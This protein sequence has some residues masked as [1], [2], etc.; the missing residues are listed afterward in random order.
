MDFGV[1]EMEIMERFSKLLLGEDMSGCGNGV[2]TA[3]AIS[4]AITNLCGMSIICLSMEK[5]LLGSKK[6]YIKKKQRQ[7]KMVTLNNRLLFFCLGPTWT[8]I[9]LASSTSDN[10]IYIYKKNLCSY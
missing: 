9:L 10:R 3:L 4:N 2:S 8:Q 5:A 6:I 7:Q 1:S